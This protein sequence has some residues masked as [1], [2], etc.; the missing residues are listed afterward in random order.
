VQVDVDPVAAPPEDLAV[1][2]PTGGVAANWRRA[3]LPRPTWWQSVLSVVVGLVLW[4]VLVDLLHPN[5]L[6]WQ[7]PTQVIDAARNLAESGTLWTDVRVGLEEFFIGFFGGLVL[8]VA[9]GVALGASRRLN[10]IFSPWLTIFY[11]VPIIALAPLIIIWFGI[12][13]LAKEVVVGLAVFFPI[14]INTRSGVQSV[15]SGMRDVCTAFRAS[16]AEKLRYA[17]LPGSVP[18]TLAGVRISVGRGL[19]ALIFADFFGATAGIGLLITTGQQTLNTGAVYVGIVI[20]AVLGLALTAVVSLLEKRFASY[21]SAS[22][23]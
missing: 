1:R 11:T 17:L 3:G 7:S 2:P 18:Y 10:V 23:A 22:A 8:G 16:R 20:L 5:P 13:M 12:G 6:V 21:R 4:Q 9:A 19:V 15:D 14:A